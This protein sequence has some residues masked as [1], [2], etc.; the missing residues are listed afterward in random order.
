M[1]DYGVDTPEWRPLPWSW[2]GERLTRNRN[3]WVVTVSATGRPHALPVW[4]V[5]DDDVRRFAFSCAPSSTKARNLAT[6]PAVVVAID[7]TVECV[8]VE[9]DATVLDDG[10]LREDW[11]RRYVERYRPEAADLD[12]DFV[13]QNLVVEVVPRRAFGIV[14]RED[15]F[16]TRATRW[17]F[18]P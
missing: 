15:E 11:I 2:A 16:A 10:P 8:S 13:R 7:D 12:A 6:N 1:P 9:G 5:W 3:F 4:G 14:E 18:G 17:V